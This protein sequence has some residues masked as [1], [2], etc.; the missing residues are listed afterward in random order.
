MGK[1]GPYGHESC[2]SAAGRG[3][4]PYKGKMIM[5]AMTSRYL[6]TVCCFLIGAAWVRAQGTPPFISVEASPE[7]GSL[8]VGEPIALVVTVRNATD[9]ELELPTRLDMKT[10]TVVIEYQDAAGEFV[11]IG[12]FSVRDPVRN[13]LVLGP[14]TAISERFVI[15]ERW[16]PHGKTKLLFEHARQITFKVRVALSA[17]IRGQA[18]VSVNLHEPMVPADHEALQLAM[19]E[20]IAGMLNAP[21][22]NL[23]ESQKGAFANIAEGESTYAPYAALALGR[24]ALSEAGL[25]QERAEMHNLAVEAKRWAALADVEGFPLRAEAVLLERHVAVATRDEADLVRLDRRIGA[26]FQGDPTFG[27]NRQRPRRNRIQHAVPK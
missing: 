10:Q 12:T 11:R 6:L 14:G 15:H 27:A 26:E 24:R 19:D 18:I 17:Q 16:I 7:Q 1:Y 20:G 5:N 25:A 21:W 2:R 4:L 8:L 22:G 23:T 3:P 13:P 9:E